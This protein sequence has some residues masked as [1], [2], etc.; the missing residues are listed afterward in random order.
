MDHIWL[1]NDVLELHSDAASTVGFAAIFKH[2]WF[3]GV[4]DSSCSHLHIT[5]MELYPICIAIKLWA[6]ELQNKCL[7]IYTDNQAVSYILNAFTSKENNIMKLVR[8]LVHICMK[9]NILI[10]SSHLS[11]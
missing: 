2:E 3:A 4:W 11:G 10:R 9:Y 5:I 7:H 1:S 8:F 6:L